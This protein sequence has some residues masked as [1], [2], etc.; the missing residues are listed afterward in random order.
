MQLI[1]IGVPD[2]HFERLEN[3]ARRAGM[4]TVTDLIEKA[5]MLMQDAVECV[6]G[7]GHIF[8]RYKDGSIARV[9]GLAPDA[10]DDSKPVPPLDIGNAGSGN[11]AHPA[12][13]LIEVIKKLGWAGRGIKILRE[14]NP[15]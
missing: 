6:E 11:H 1:Q 10:E 4:D 15:K 5:L 8:F 14:E 7:G 2:E 13:I 12:I 3:L 9:C